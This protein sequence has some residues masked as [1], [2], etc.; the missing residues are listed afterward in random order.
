MNAN[1][2]LAY[3]QRIYTYTRISKGLSCVDCYPVCELIYVFANGIFMK[4]LLVS[5][6]LPKSFREIHLSHSFYK[7]ILTGRLKSMLK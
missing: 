7:R 2:D 5:L 4:L 6:L 3:K 1:Y